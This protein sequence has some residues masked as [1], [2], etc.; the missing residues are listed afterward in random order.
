MAL[1]FCLGLIVLS[2]ELFS[3]H[4]SLAQTSLNQTPQGLW[5]SS[6]FNYTDGFISEILPTQFQ[7]SGIPKRAFNTGA[8]LVGAP[9]KIA[10]DRAGNLW[11]PF[12]PENVQGTVVA[13]SPSALK[14][15][16]A[17]RFKGVRVAAELSDSIPA[18][19]VAVAFDQ[20][21]NLWIAQ[22][23]NDGPT[24]ALVEYAASDLFSAGAQPSRILTSAPLQ[25]LA[26]IAFDSNGNLWAADPTTNVYEFTPEQ[27]SSGGTQTPNLTL[28]ST[29][30]GSED[31]AFDSAGNLWVPYYSG[32]G[33]AQVGASPNG[34]VIKYLSTDLGGT[35]AKSPSPAVT[36]T[37][38]I[39]CS[40][41]DLCHA[42]SEAF[43]SSGNLWVS[44]AKFIF[45]Y[46]PQQQLTGGSPL[47][48]VILATNIYDVRYPEVRPLNFEGDTF[49]VFAPEI[50]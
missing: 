42:F 2:L 44:T 28:Q 3:S 45:E 18:C 16:A 25:R 6:S 11:I 41:L 9:G 32:P 33:A 34:A 43:D 12:C 19:P 15:I 49:L 31:V 20:S 21:G 22:S 1:R 35:G 5:I 36:L 38:P 50:K 26:G 46:S 10:F 13:L 8:S 48:A 7:H 40:P 47:A 30:F 39:P 37:G 14:S 27:V 29:F 23:S 24:P 17:N 4:P